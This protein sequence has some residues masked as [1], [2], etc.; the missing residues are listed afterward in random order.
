MNTI[1]EN[2]NTELK[3]KFDNDTISKEIVAF[4]N[5]YDGKIYIGITSKREVVGATIENDKDKLDELLRKVSDIITDQISP[6]CVELVEIK[7]IVIDNK[8]IVEIDVKKGNELYY[9]KKYGMSE[10]GCFIREGTTVKTLQ[11]DE[12]KKKI[13]RNIKYPKANNNYYDTV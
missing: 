7:H 3:Q 4:L 5:S 9:H 1:F 12:I 2:H 13:Y 6:S 11:S 8:D 10:R